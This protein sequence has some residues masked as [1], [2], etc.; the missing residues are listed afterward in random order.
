[1]FKCQLDVSKTSPM[2]NTPLLVIIIDLLNLQL[3]NIFSGYH[4]ASRLEQR[5]F[6][7]APV[8]D[9]VVYVS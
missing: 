2:R 1:M 9:S 7:L 8:Y 4:T 5:Y 3:N 6:G